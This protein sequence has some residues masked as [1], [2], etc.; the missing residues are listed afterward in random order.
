MV[1]PPRVVLRLVD[2]ISIVVFKYKS[3]RKTQYLVF[4][5]FWLL[6]IGLERRLSFFAGYEI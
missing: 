4:L 5:Y 1:I 6:D 2:D 3:S